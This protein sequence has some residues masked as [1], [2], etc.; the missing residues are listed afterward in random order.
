M[1]IPLVDE[2]VE[3]EVVNVQVEGGLWPSGFKCMFREV[4]ALRKAPYIFDC[5]CGRTC[6]RSKSAFVLRKGMCDNDVKVCES[7]SL[8]R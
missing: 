2:S 8:W 5:R 6:P 1:V 3:I 7:D 4:T